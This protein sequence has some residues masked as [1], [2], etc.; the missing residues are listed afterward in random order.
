MEEI[1]QISLVRRKTFGHGAAMTGRP[2]R[3]M[4]VDQSLSGNLLPLIFS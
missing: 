3:Q 1:E 2:G 4:A